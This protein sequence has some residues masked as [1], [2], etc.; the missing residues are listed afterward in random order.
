VRLEGRSNHRG[1]AASVDHCKKDGLHAL[2]TGVPPVLRHADPEMLAIAL[3]GLVEIA[4]H[5]HHPEALAA[6]A[7]SSPSA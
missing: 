2:T 1:P 6:R 4:S 5:R 3:M 7:S